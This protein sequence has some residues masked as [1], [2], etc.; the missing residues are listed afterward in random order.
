MKQMDK[1]LS[2]ELSQTEN[3]QHTAQLLQE[4]FDRE[5]RQKWERMLAEEHQLS[6]QPKP[7]RRHL[8][9]YL[10]VA[11]SLAFLLVLGQ[12][13]YQNSTASPIELADSYLE[14]SK[15]EEFGGVLRA[16]AAEDIPALRKDANT[17]YAQDKYKEAVSYAQQIIATGNAKPQD[18]LLLGLSHLYLNDATTSIDIFKKGQESSQVA[19]KYVN[20][21]NWFLSLS[22]LKAQQPEMAR[23]ILENIVQHQKWNHETAQK[24]LKEL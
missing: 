11:A 15:M 23:P 14:N 21:M 3:E 1:Y 16:G 4:K 19:K 7:W 5:T 17:A 24:M 2:G 12:L 9:K 20:E 13:F 6:R 18:F 10:A 8:Y 22:Y